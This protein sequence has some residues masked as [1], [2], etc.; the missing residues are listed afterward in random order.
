MRG[1][2]SGPWRVN[3]RSDPLLA[4]LKLKLTPG[5]RAGLA[6]ILFM[7]YAMWMAAWSGFRN[8]GP[9][10]GVS[11]PPRSSHDAE[12]A[13]A[14]QNFAPSIYSLST[15][16]PRRIV[17]VWSLQLHGATAPAASLAGEFRRTSITLRT[18]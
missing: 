12:A 2:I 6:E 5:M 13:V 14:L 11:T 10:S 8:L 9:E 4:R 1:Q 7:V 16:Q 18:K 17:S 15:S 3:V